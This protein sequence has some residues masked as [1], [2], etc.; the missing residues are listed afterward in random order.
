[1]RLAFSGLFNLIQSYWTEGRGI[2]GTEVSS[3]WTM[4]IFFSKLKWARTEA[5]IMEPHGPTGDMKL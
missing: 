4:L 5:N 1:M 2:K 3:E